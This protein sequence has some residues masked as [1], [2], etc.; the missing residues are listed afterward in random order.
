MVMNSKDNIFK[1]FISEDQKA[2]NCVK[3]KIE[4]I[5]YND[6]ITSNNRGE[7][8]EAE[9][10]YK[11]LTKEQ[12]KLVPGNIVALLRS[13]HDACDKCDI[14]ETVKKIEGIGKVDINS[15]SKIIEARKNYNKLDTKLKSSIPDFSLKSLVNAEK[16]YDKLVTNDVTDKIN[17][18]GNVG[19]TTECKSKI[20][21]A[22]EAFS[23][24]S[25]KQ[26][27]LVNSDALIAA[28]NKYNELAVENGKQAAKNVDELI[29]NIGKIEFTDNCKLKIKEAR[30][31]FDKLSERQK[32]L[33]NQKALIDAENEYNNLTIENDNKSSVAHVEKLISEIGK[34]EILGGYEYKLR[35]ARE[36][37]DKLSEKQKQLVNQEALKALT[38][39]KSK[40]E[41]ISKNE[42]AEKL[43]QL[44]KK[45][46][47]DYD[48]DIDNAADIEIESLGDPVGLG[49][50]LTEMLAICNELPDKFG[51][52]ISEDHLLQIQNAKE[53]YKNY[54]MNWL[55]TNFNKAKKVK[56]ST[57][58]ITKFLSLCEWIKKNIGGDNAETCDK[59]VKELDDVL[60]IY[61]TNVS[62]K[63]IEKIEDLS[64]KEVTEDLC[65]DIKKVRTQY[66]K[67]TKEQKDL[68][69]ES[70]K[71]LQEVEQKC[72]EYVANNITKKIDEI[73]N[74][75][76]NGLDPASAIKK[77]YEEYD[78]LTPEQQKYVSNEK[79]ES[80]KNT[81][82]KY[83][84]YVAQIVIDK[85]DNI[86]KTEINK[87]PAWNIRN[88]H[89][90]YNDLT[91]AQQKYISKEKLDSL[92]EIKNKYA[93][94]VEEEI[95]RISKIEITN[96]NKSDVR[97]VNEAFERLSDIQ[98]SLVS[99]S[100][101]S[102]L[103]LA[104]KQCENYDRAE[105]V[106]EKIKEIVFPITSTNMDK[107]KW[108][109]EYYN[110]YK[111]DVEK[112]HWKDLISETPCAN[113]LEN[114]MK[115]YK[116]FKEIDEVIRLI[117]YIDKVIT[118]TSG[119]NIDIARSAYDNLSKEQQSKITNYKKLTDAET[120]YASFAKS[121]AQSAIDNIT[122]DKI[123]L[124]PES[125]LMIQRARMLYEKL[126]SEQQ[127]SISGSEKLVDA[128]NKYDELAKDYVI[129]LINNI[130]DVKLGGNCESK[131]SDARDAFESLSSKMKNEVPTDL[132]ETL[133]KAENTL[134]SLEDDFKSDLNKIKKPL[135][136]IDQFYKDN[137]KGFKEA[138]DEQLK[139]GLDLC[140]KTDEGM[141]NENSIDI[142]GSNN[143]VQNLEKLAKG[144][145][146]HPVTIN[147]LFFMIDQIKIKE[148]YLNSKFENTSTTVKDDAFDVDRKRS[149]SEKNVKDV[150]NK[151]DG[152]DKR[153][154]ENLFSQIKELI[155]EIKPKSFFDFGFHSGESRSK[156]IIS[157]LRNLLL[158][159]KLDLC[160]KEAWEVLLPEEKFEK[161]AALEHVL[162]SKNGDTEI[163]NAVKII[164]QYMKANAGKNV[165][166]IK[167]S[168]LMWNVSKKGEPD[169]TEDDIH[170]GNTNTCWL[171]SFL[172]S[173]IRNDPKLIVN[174]FPKYKDEI[175]PD[176]TVKGTTITVRL[177]R[178]LLSG[179]EKN[180]GIRLY[181]RTFGKHIDISMNATVTDSDYGNKADVCWPRFLEKAMSIARTKDLVL[182]ENSSKEDDPLVNIVLNCSKREWNK[183]DLN[184]DSSGWGFNAG[185]TQAMITGH[186]SGGFSV[187]FFNSKLSNVHAVQEAYFNYVKKH[188]EKK[189][190]I[191]ATCAETFDAS[192]SGLEVLGSHAWSLQKAYVKNGQKTIKLLNPYNNSSNIQAGNYVDVSIQE[193]MEHFRGI[194]I[195]GIKK[196]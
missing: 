20:D 93:K 179:H 96:D 25:S 47:S 102:K 196:I 181:A 92:E 131:I 112:E 190:N 32:Q 130:G 178:V 154:L 71:L 48:F 109:S 2:A 90:M 99:N 110:A 52:H 9:N 95:N 51:L 183:S 119:K 26:E 33:V 182:V 117:N 123:E 185:I 157:S 116:E 4:R 164:L 53:S 147:Y 3:S 42:K 184:W 104:M 143:V 21:A 135:K 46:D 75:A 35:E 151:F 81:Q 175:N 60:K 16:E 155:S 144:K 41:K 80:L 6:K 165:G 170:Q 88:V 55:E 91:P 97:K 174:C 140:I 70:I 172:L 132:Q 24:L 120:A 44:Y 126:S 105:R 145:S 168:A 108:A 8:K 153:N 85:I 62:K 79:L 86:N 139:R 191:V 115:E 50:L 186:T 113:T 194:S 166:W 136:N 87:D 28:E 36:A 101:K 134:E 64:K 127:K 129:N 159:S 189:H 160:K 150:I 29:R 23:K 13:A 61:N 45:S 83:D 76:E 7:I 54:A 59:Y 173:A 49:T 121:D 195:G 111:Y 12:A 68:V 38:D 78:K 141:K 74:N 63:F 56:K 169:I 125:K 30:E 18:I 67:M 84:K 192:D 94:Y 146:I 22:R 73:I 11:S 138:F 43:K 148:H 39:A 161:L 1:I 176:G 162:P 163:E 10:A 31:A 137:S 58:T 103:K 193:F 124:C 180:M 65:E 27:A 17:N 66:E 152:S 5:C 69:G 118:K 167:P 77:V 128:E 37:F 106:Q 15:A 177:W 149:I 107:V 82:Q 98:K 100:S 14:E 158:T 187:G 188:L 114:A 89:L 133:N 156:I 122:I 19:F 40:H 72:D 57:G 171:L 34:I 142:L